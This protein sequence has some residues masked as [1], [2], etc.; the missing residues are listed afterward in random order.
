MSAARSAWMLW[1]R[2]RSRQVHG[3]TP[4]AAADA[5]LDLCVS[6]GWGCDQFDQWF[7][8]P[9]PAL[10]GNTPRDMVYE[11]AGAEVWEA[12]ARVDEPPE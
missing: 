7:D 3:M 1:F 8:S 6:K 11:G 10:A 4:G 2:L 12:I 9:C 5:I